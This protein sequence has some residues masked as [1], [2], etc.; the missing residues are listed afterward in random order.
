MLR[1]SNKDYESC[2]DTVCAPVVSGASAARQLS[3][4]V[5]GVA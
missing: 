4:A 3:A 1:L 2:V 5:L